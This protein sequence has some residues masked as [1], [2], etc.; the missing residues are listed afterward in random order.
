MLFLS[1]DLGRDPSLA[2]GAYG[3]RAV[4]LPWYIKMG[5]RQRS[6]SGPLLAYQRK[7]ETGLTRTTYGLPGLDA[8]LATS[9]SRP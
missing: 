9:R 3:G 2:V 6:K 4:W 1:L 7:T 8:D 5:R